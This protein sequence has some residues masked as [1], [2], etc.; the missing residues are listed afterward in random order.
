MVEYC[1]ES[2][3]FWNKKKSENLN[4]N[5]HTTKLFEKL[6]LDLSLKFDEIYTKLNTIEKKVELMEKNFEK[7]EFSD[8]QLYGHLKYKIQE[9]KSS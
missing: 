7:K 8:K 1:Q 9:V 2:S 5:E 3:M 6:H 4:I